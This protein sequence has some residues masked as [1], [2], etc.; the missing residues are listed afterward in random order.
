MIYREIVHTCSNSN[1]AR[2]ALDSIGGDFARHFAADASRRALTRGAWAAKLV[3]E[4]ADRADESERVSVAV[5]AHGSDHPVLTG[6]RYILE[7]AVN[8]KTDDAPPA[9]MISASR[10]AA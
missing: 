5:A 2:A 3:R 1:V 8:E 7:R 4:F 6:L 9:W 10:S